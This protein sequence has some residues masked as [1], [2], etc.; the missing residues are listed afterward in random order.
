MNVCF[1]MLSR[2]VTPDSCLE[3]QHTFEEK[4]FIRSM[5]GTTVHFIG[6]HL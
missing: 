6:F 1:S 4:T 5:S 2:Y 3:A